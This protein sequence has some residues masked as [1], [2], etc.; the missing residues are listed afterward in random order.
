MMCSDTATS[1]SLYDNDPYD[2]IAETKLTME[3]ME[4]DLEQVERV[5]YNRFC[6]SEAPDTPKA[7]LGGLKP[8]ISHFHL[9]LLGKR[10]CLV[11]KSGWLGRVGK[12]KKG[13]L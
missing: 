9:A 12:R 7:R 6:W 11:P 1:T 13:K 2:S 3:R 10:Q 4:E 8:S 5:E